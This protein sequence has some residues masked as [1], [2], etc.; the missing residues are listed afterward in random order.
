MFQ[1]DLAV[2]DGAENKASPFIS[3]QKNT[4]PGTGAAL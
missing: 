1:R 4:A 2:I 3:T